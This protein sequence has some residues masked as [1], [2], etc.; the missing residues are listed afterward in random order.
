MKVLQEALKLAVVLA[1]AAL[2][3]WLGT[4]GLM[5][6]SQTLKELRP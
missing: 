5:D 2:V 6:L 4:H 3:A 1:L